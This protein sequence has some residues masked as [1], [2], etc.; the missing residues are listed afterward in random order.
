MA[1]HPDMAG[2]SPGRQAQRMRSKDM[3]HKEEKALNDN[4]TTNMLER[5]VSSNDNEDK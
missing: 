3:Q 2:R 4:T 5:E 1:G